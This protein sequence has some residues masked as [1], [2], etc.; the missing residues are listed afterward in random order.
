MRGLD[1]GLGAQCAARPAACRFI[2]RVTE[3]KGV[4]GG[5]AGAFVRSLATYDRAWFCLQPHGDTPTRQ[6]WC[7]AWAHG[8]NIWC[9]VVDTFPLRRG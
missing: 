7:G 6:A 8:A 2:E 5:D 3:A 9:W 4:L 1:P